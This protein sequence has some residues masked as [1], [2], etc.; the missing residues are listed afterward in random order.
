MPSQ[1]Y[2][3]LSEEELIDYYLWVKDYIKRGFQVEG[4]KD[5]LQM[6]YNTIEVKV[7]TSDKDVYL[8][9][10]KQLMNEVNY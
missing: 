10:I 4:L 3:Q 2:E 7:T 6:I 9:E 5:E 8:N 1:I